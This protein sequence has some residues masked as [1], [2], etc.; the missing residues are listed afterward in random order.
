MGL[1][2]NFDKLPVD[3]RF[4]WLRLYFRIKCPC[5]NTYAKKPFHNNTLYACKKCGSIYTVVLDCESYFSSSWEQAGNAF[6]IEEVTDLNKEIDKSD[7]TF[8]W[9]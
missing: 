5:G 3:V 2:Q 6:K 1:R 4:E 9:F 8:E 7:L